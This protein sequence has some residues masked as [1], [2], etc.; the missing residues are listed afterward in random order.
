MSSTRQGT[1]RRGT[2]CLCAWALAG[3]VWA[4]DPAQ[5]CR[6][7]SG[8]LPR[9]A[10]KFSLGLAACAARTSETPAAAAAP[11]A[12]QLYLYEPRDTQPAS[13]AATPGARAA[14]PPARLTS[15]AR[16]ALQ[17]ASTVDAAARASDIDPLLLHAIAFVESRHD[18]AAVSSAGALGVMQLMPGTAGRFGASPAQALNDVPTNLA[19]GAAYLK[20]LQRRFGNDLEL[21]LAAYNAGEGAVER[22]GRRIPPFA[23]TRSYVRNVLAEYAR[24]R[25]AAQRPPSGAL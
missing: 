15:S 3:G 16:R 4:G 10:S 11:R 12:Q 5:D 1:A 24:L 6:R 2:F 14:P 25:S 23:E 19:V 21:V 8:D 13:A 9:L 22:H 18:P 17:L 20:T 7:L